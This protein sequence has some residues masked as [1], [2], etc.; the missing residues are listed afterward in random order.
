LIA[1][2]EKFGCFCRWVGIFSRLV[3]RKS[4]LAPSDQLREEPMVNRLKAS[5]PESAKLASPNPVQTDALSLS[6]KWRA[7]T[8]PI[9]S[10]SR[11]SGMPLIG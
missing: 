9:I 8:S 1:Q 2:V 3:M 6:S 4:C 7:D 10:E 5:Q 11:A